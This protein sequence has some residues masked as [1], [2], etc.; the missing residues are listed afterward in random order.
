MAVDSTDAVVLRLQDYREVDRLA[1]LL[2][3]ERGRV[4]A[5]ARG[6]RRSRKRFGGHLDLFQRVRVRVSHAS[7][8]LHALADCRVEEAWPR[9][10]T[11]VERYAAASF[12][13]ELAIALS[14]EEAED[15]GLYVAVTGALR[16]LDDDRTVI[17]AATAAAVAVRMLTPSGFLLDLATCSTCGRS[18]LD[19]DGNEAVEAGVEEGCG[20]P[21]LEPGGA[22][23]EPGGRLQC[24]DCAP[25]DPGGADEDASGGRRL[26]RADVTALARWQHAPLADAVAAPGGPTAVA[27]VRGLL[28]EVLGHSLKS[29]P[30]LWEIV[31]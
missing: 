3:S 13:A 10:R 20:G 21:P 12:V 28:R 1:W 19:E 29:E 14:Q 25:P 7:G 11:D 17:T 26:S 22:L 30:F 4:S 16:L 24:A 31:R 2:T 23:L 15:A 6:A 27:A 9:L 8:T 18:F 5:I